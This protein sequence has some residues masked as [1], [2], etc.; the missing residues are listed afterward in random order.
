MIEEIVAA[1]SVD[2]PQ[3]SSRQETIGQQDFLRM[4]IAQLEN[5]DPLDP[6]DGTE[7]TAQLAQFTSLEQLVAMRESIDR[8]ANPTERNATLEAAALIDRE[9]LAESPAVD[10]SEGERPR[11]AVELAQSAD[12]VTVELRSSAGAVVGRAALGA[13][14]P[15][16]TT[17]EWPDDSPVPSGTYFVEISA[18]AA[19]EAVA[20]TPLVR[21]RVTAVSSEG[22][23]VTVQLGDLGV[24]LSDIR[25][26]QSRE[27]SR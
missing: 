5:Q 16:V 11:L 18:Q 13:L 10:V 14:P 27:E 6:Q 2:E 7:F 25:S 3:E 4:L 8:L 17:I 22:G 23:N 24:P 26:I 19:N 20:T 9:V 1:S 12:N 15:G 21:G